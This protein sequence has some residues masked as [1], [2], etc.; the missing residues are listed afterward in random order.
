MLITCICQ[1]PSSAKVKNGG[2]IPQVLRG[3]VLNELGTGTTLHIYI[4]RVVY[5]C[6][7]LMPEV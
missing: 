1:L 6:I 3:M 7:A 5:I 2:A 4:T